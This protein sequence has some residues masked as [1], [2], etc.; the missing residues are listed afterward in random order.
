MVIISCFDYNDAV[1]LLPLINQPR[2]WFSG[3]DGGFKQ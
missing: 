2:Q 1:F 3:I